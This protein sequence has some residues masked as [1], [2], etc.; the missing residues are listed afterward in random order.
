[1]LLERGAWDLVVVEE[2]TAT[3]IVWRA[4]RETQLLAAQSGQVQRV[5]QEADQWWEIEVVDTLGSTV[6]IRARGRALVDSGERVIRTQ[7]IFV[8]D[9][10]GAMERVRIDWMAPS[11]TIP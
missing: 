7:P 11:S 8:V 4:L 10:L 3:G 5:A 2:R 9:S 6:R 1:M